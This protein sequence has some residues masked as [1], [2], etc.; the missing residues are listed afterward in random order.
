MIRLAVIS[1]S[2]GNEYSLVRALAA[3]GEYDAVVHLGDYAAD[4]ETV[5]EKLGKPLYAVMG[6]CDFVHPPKGDFGYELLVELEG[7]KLLLVHGH[8]HGID[9]YSTYEARDLA[10]RRGA[11]ALLYGHTH[12]SEVSMKDGILV[13]NPGST[14][15]PRA[16]RKPSAGLLVIENG[17]LQAK[18]VTI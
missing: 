7:A 10:L 15:R 5:C 2:H 16:G 1:D 12:V 17:K 8:R 18:I 11:D 4:A 13:M 6:N 14:S 9:G 3:V